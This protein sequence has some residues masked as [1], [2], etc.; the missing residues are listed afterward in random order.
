LVF[1]DIYDIPYENIGINGENELRVVTQPNTLDIVSMY[2]HNKN[3]MEEEF[4]TECLNDIS[5]LSLSRK[6]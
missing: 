2:P 4:E 3:E 1:N 5:M 6:K